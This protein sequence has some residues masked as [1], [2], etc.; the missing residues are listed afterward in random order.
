MRPYDAG[1]FEILKGLVV[2]SVAMLST[3]RWLFINTLHF[4]SRFTLKIVKGNRV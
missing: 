3:V 4:Y 2:L 1:W